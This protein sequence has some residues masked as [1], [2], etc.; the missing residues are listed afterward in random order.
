MK[1]KNKNLNLLA[2]GKFTSY[3]GTTLQ[4]FALSLYVLNTTGSGTL[5]ASVLA[6]ALIPQLILGPLGGVIVD[7]I[8]KKKIIV[9][10]DIV[11]GSITLILALVFLRLGHLELWHIYT[12]VILLSL[13]S[14][15]FNPAVTSIIPEIAKEEELVN[16]NSLNSL[17]ESMASIVGPI[18]GGLLF[19]I[20]GLG[21]IIIINAF[22]FYL[23]SLSETFI[24]I[25][26]KIDTQV[27]EE[28]KDNS[29]KSFF[30]E[31]K[32]GIL[33]ICRSKE[34]MVLGFCCLIANFSLGP[35]FSVVLPYVAKRV[36]F[37]TDF[38]F[39]LL[40]G[41]I[42]LSALSGPFFV[43]IVSKKFKV[44]EII[45]GSFSLL[46][47]ISLLIALT[48][49]PIILN[50]INIYYIPLIIL[51]LLGMIAV[52]VTIITNV[53]LMT[54]LQSVI[55]EKM[56][57]R[58]FSVLTTFAMAAMPIGQMMTGKLLDIIPSY[59]TILILAVIMLIGTIAY[60]NLS[61]EDQNLVVNEN[62]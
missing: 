28:E 50:G 5:F 60:V 37:V 2:F 6:I 57:G 53:V 3:T 14:S 51:I 18:L 16:A 25:E 17:V 24:K 8:D 59:S 44:R 36:L 47:L 30:D 22:S 20:F 42:S 62:N 31:F 46:T 21:S 23:S 45:I 9:T 58:V 43:A 32:E 10:L 13:V 29:S 27:I 48:T 41:V 49:T 4:N 7:R 56:R 34:L 40:E 54:R 55:E 1:I 12:A 61:E 52:T 26:N 11:S 35:L 39:G 33:Y 15:M 19:S 38:Q